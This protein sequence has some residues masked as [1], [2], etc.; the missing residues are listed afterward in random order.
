[1]KQ[2]FG[3]QTEK[4]QQNFPFSLA[5]VALELI[6]ALAEIKKAAALSN[7]NTDSLAPNIADTI[8]T[9]CDE[10]LEKKYDTQ[11]VTCSLQ[12]GAGTSINMN[13][14][15]VIS[16]R[17]TEL[18]AKKN[19][20]VVVHPNDHVNLHQSTNDVNPSALRIL[21]I[22][23]GNSLIE[24]VGS[25]VS[26]LET[27][28]KK[29]KKVRKLGRTHIQDAVPT[30]VGEEFLAYA[31][32]IER[33]CRR[34]LNALDY[35]YELN[36]GGTAIG[37]KVNSSDEYIEALYRHL[38]D[39]THLNLKPAKNM[40]ALTSSA[41]D[42]CTLSSSIHL[43][44]IDLS[45]IASDIRFLSSG[46]RG[47][48][49]EIHLPELQAGSS[50]M[51]GKVNP[52]I[53][54]VIN[55]VYYFISGKHLSITQAAASSHLEL[56]IMFPVVSDALICELNIAQEA[57]NLFKDKCIETLEVDE[58]R[59]EELLEKSS[60]YATLFTKRL[61]YDTVSSVVKESQ[62]S[63]KTFHQIIIDTH[64]LTEEEFDSIL[65]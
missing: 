48:I 64:L 20:P 51:P 43:L 52:V 16:A 62:V 41:T 36:L 37:N 15:E 40:M 10:I 39:I 46:P 28:A 9:V 45:K 58:K 57:I 29:Y 27:K 42:F 17:A 54:E 59:C 7:K 13:V 24:A 33:D 47:G 11:F 6:Y 18:L 23:L 25:L 34:I 22:R 2:Y 12:G 53:P 55:Q 5:P 14:N 19:K 3:S 4:A 31:A 49:G 50:I 38:K 65:Q 60:A 8:S 35:M 30:T 63:G 21:C 32:I 44:F 61:G 1:M 56:A 26:M